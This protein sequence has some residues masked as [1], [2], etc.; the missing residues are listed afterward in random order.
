[1]PLIAVIRQAV[2]AQDLRFAREKGFKFAAS[3]FNVWDS[4]QAGCRREEE[5]EV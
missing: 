1:M 3:W 5:L 4:I 2:D